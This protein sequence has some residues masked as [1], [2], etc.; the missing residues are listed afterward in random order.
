MLQA[1]QPKVVNKDELQ[2]AVARQSCRRGGLS[3]LVNDVRHAFGDDERPQFVT[4][5]R[6][7][8]DESSSRSR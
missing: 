3:V 4:M 5:G 2:A 7:W 6:F 1:H 8:D